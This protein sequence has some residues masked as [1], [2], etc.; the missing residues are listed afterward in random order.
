MKNIFVI[1]D[2]H[3]NQ[4]LIISFGRRPF[5]SVRAMND[6]IVENWNKVVRSDDIVIVVGDLFFGNPVKAKAII[7]KLNGKIVLVTGNHDTRKRIKNISSM[8]DIIIRNSLE[9]ELGGLKLLFTHKPSRFLEDTV[10]RFDLNIHGHH[11]R[12]LRSDRLKHDV[13][14]N[15][16]VEFNDY[17]PKPLSHVLDKKNIRLKNL[18]FSCPKLEGLLEF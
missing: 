17:C 10:D 7:D 1:S 6:T 15:A 9:F 14:Y 12:K 13:Y 16:A 18:N 5:K 4:S 11:H 2:T 8:T 3:F